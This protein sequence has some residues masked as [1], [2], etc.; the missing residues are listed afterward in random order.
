VSDHLA[1]SVCCVSAFLLVIGGCERPASRREM[2]GHQSAL[3]ARYARQSASG[4]TGA[5][6]SGEWSRLVIELG[7]L[8]QDGCWRTGKDN[9]LL[10][11]P[12]CEMALSRVRQ[13]RDFIVSM[14]EEG[15]A[16]TERSSGPE[17]P[18]GVRCVERGLLTLAAESLA[19]GDKGEALRCLEAVHRL[20]RTIQSCDAGSLMAVTSIALEDD[21]LRFVHDSRPYL[22]S[23][24]FDDFLGRFRTDSSLGRT[25]AHFAQ[26]LTA[27]NVGCLAYSGRVRREKRRVLLQVVEHNSRLVQLLE[28]HAGGSAALAEVMAALDELQA[29]LREHRDADLLSLSVTV[30]PIFHFAR[31]DAEKRAIPGN[32]MK[33]LG[34]Q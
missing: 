3:N 32:D 31:V 21:L 29:Y 20:I 13:E 27:Y 14:M 33:T 9:V 12:A 34:T 19:E 10:V 7:G 24:V 18:L 2:I 8:Y 1:H 22:S 26:E 4:R 30:A 16:L 11:G 25:Y 23:P 6:Q 15:A 5:R 28:A 17:V